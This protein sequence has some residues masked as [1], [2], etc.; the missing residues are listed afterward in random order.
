MVVCWWCD[1]DL[2]A[3]L[4][5]NQGETI[6]TPQE[7]CDLTK[8]H[9]DLLGRFPGQSLTAGWSGWL[10]QLCP[11]K[12]S[13]KSGELEVASLQE[14]SITSIHSSRVPLNVSSIFSDVRRSQLWI[15]LVVI[16]VF[17]VNKNWKHRTRC[18]FVIG[19]HTSTL[20]CPN[21][22]SMLQTRLKADFQ[23]IDPLVIWYI[24]MKN[25]HFYNVGPPNDS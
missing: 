5:E 9:R 12:F 11:G 16:R 1:G 8:K 23:R 20:M 10:C 19:S 18:V 17:F 13:S 3:I 2:M 25:H 24:T 6:G 21:E 7:N 14:T 4:R 15:R 22:R